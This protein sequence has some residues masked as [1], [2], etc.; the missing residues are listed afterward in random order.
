MSMRLIPNYKCFVQKRDIE[1]VRI[2][3]PIRHKWVKTTDVSNN[4]NGHRNDTD[5]KVHSSQVG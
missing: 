5:W 4:E 2:G 3:K 1:M